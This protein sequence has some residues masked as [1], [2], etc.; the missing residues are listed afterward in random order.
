MTTN[1]NSLSLTP[2]QAV[3]AHQR[4]AALLQALLEVDRQGVRSLFSEGAAVNAKFRKVT[5]FKPYLFEKK[6]LR[7]PGLVNMVLA[8]AGIP[9][10]PHLEDEDNGLVERFVDRSSYGL[11]DQDEVPAADTPAK[12]PVGRPRTPVE[13]LTESDWKEL[14]ILRRLRRQGYPLAARAQKNLR[15]LEAHQRRFLYQKANPK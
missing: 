5:A 4:V 9:Q 11:S 6:V 12:R 1:T 8:A 15:D 13:A 2:A 3:H 14:R 10:V 7:V